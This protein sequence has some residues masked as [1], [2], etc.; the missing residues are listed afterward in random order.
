MLFVRS[1]L[2]EELLN[3]VQTIF[4]TLD[5]VPVHSEFEI[6]LS[7]IKRIRRIR[8][9]IGTHNN[10]AFKIDRKARDGLRYIYRAQ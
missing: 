4:E 10:Y 3:I 9:S 6:G 2:N 5:F 1:D 8:L 7:V